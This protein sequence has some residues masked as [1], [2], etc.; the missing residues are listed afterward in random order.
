MIV[1]KAKHPLATAWD[2][3]RSSVLAIVGIAAI[4]APVMAAEMSPFDPL[5][6]G[7]FFDGAVNFP[8]NDA[9]K[10][11]YDFTGPMHYR[12]AFGSQPDYCEVAKTGERLIIEKIPNY[13]RNAWDL[14][15]VGHPEVN[16]VP[17]APGGPP[18]PA[19]IPTA[20]PAKP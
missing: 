10:C 8:A 15:F 18:L 6:N 12:H 2:F 7:V 17:A 5:Y 4:S 14:R 19:R 20:F 16:T 3:A 1:K 13:H 9:Y 11:L